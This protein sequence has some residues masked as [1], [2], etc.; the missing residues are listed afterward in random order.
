MVHIAL[1]TVGPQ[2]LQRPKLYVRWT[3]LRDLQVP[4]KLPFQPFPLRK[5][6][7]IPEAQVILDAQE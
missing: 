2:F 5:V 1:P 6:A 3:G 4:E 7:D